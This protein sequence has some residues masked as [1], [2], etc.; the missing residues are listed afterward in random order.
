MELGGLTHESERVFLLST[1]HGGETHSLAAAQAT[2]AELRERDVAKHLWT[3]GER[4]SEGLNE[5]ARREHVDEGFSCSGYPCSP[6]LTF[7]D[8]GNVSAGE[9]RTLFL[10]EMVRRGVLIPY[11]APSYS[12]GP[13]EVDR[14]TEAA[15]AAFAVV[16]RV[17]EGEP[18]EK[19]LVGPTVK[20]VFRRSN[21]DH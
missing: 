16:R 12:H 5:A 18:L 3:I 10:Q 2:I 11:V 1:T 17:L 14:T 20:P 4:L 9:L 15:E 7:S 6:V 21:F 13:E 19:H 8:V